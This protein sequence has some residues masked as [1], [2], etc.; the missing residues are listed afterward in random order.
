MRANQANESSESTN[1]RIKSESDQ[2]HGSASLLTL[3]KPSDLAAGLWRNESPRRLQGLVLGGSVAGWRCGAD[4]LRLVDLVS[5]APAI[6]GASA[7]RPE[8]VGGDKSDSSA[9]PALALAPAS[10]SPSSS[11][12][13]SSLSSLLSSFMFINVH[14][15]SLTL[16][17]PSHGVTEPLSAESPKPSHGSQKPPLGPHKIRRRRAALT[18]LELIVSVVIIGVV[19]V[20]MADSVAR[21]T[22]SFARLRQGIDG[23]DYAHRI[24]NALISERLPTFSGLDSR[25]GAEGSMEGGSAILTEE[26]TYLDFLESIGADMS[27]YTERDIEEFLRWEYVW[28]K[29][30]IVV[31]R[32]G[33]YEP[34]ED[35][36][37]PNFGDYNEYDEMLRDAERNNEV[38]DEPSPEDLESLPAARLVRIKLV[39]WVPGRRDFDLDYDPRGGY[40]GYDRE[41]G[42]AGQSRGSRAGRN[43][44]TDPNKIVLMTYVDLDDFKEP[45]ADSDAAGADGT[46]PQ[47][48]PTTGPGAGGTG[49]N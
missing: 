47:P 32:E 29:E 38:I 24:M 46:Q 40:S 44:A 7:T 25:E 22:A 10:S 14:S 12:L 48:P 5:G 34:Y 27:V 43:E 35:G 28:T 45:P 17:K 41:Q 33:L 19:L 3:F 39:L 31:N 36:S 13:S 18:L 20:P 2:G 15:C 6:T 42:F 23:H 9:T 26:A 49:G 30:L 11:L 4:W 16:L 1:D 8:V 37:G 21:A